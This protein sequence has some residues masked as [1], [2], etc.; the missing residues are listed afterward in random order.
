MLLA[1]LALSTTAVGLIAVELV[2]RKIDGYRLT[3]WRLIPDRM[4]VTPEEE[5]SASPELV[6]AFLTEHATGDLQASWFATSP[7]LVPAFETSARLEER[8][9]KF[10]R[11]F[12]YIINDMF[13][14]ALWVPGKGIEVLG[15]AA[16]PDDFTSFAAVGGNPHPFY[17]Y[18]AS[19]TLPTGLTTN[20]FGFRGPERAV[21]KPPRT[22]RI[23]CVGASTTVNSHFLPH[24][25]P[26]LLEHYLTL[27]AEAR[28]LDVRFEVF[29]AGREAIES[30]DIRGIVE[31][32]LAP[33]EVDFV[34]YYEGANQMH[35]EDFR[36]HVT[37]A[38]ASTVWNR[39]P[40]GLIPDEYGLTNDQG[41][42]LDRVAAYS[43]TASR[44]R[45]MLRGSPTLYELDKPDYS[46][47]LPEDLNEGL[48]AR[49]PNLEPATQFASGGQILG[50]LEGIRNACVETGAELVL[51]TYTWLVSDGMELDAWKGNLVYQQLHR[52]FWP[53]R[54]AT[55]RQFVDIQN[56]MYR[57]YASQH[58]LHL[59]D[60]ADATPRE[61][62]LFTDAIHG[63][64]LGVRVRAWLV[65][66]SLTELLAKRLDEGVVPRADRAEQ[67]NHPNIGPTRTITVRDLNG[68]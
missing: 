11:V 54:Y 57:A 28:E 40:P 66:E 25:Y 9:A 17:R 38:D 34:V 3:T 20:S 8:F 14:R 6:E 47:S 46:V 42:L 60:V 21:D 18:P 61:Q 56:D 35:I 16:M 33:L 4:R 27:W 15:D 53:M 32:E 7:V 5:V 59:I 50:D 37:F 31:Q 26:E 45:E 65:F 41:R 49:P 10:E 2:L 19:S 22:I 55:L 44:L 48:Q 1:I 43:A 29:N 62:V 64:A 67:A 36:K 23:G 30:P 39:V 24:S 51:C 13:L 12:S 63:T 52:A 58:Q 68:G